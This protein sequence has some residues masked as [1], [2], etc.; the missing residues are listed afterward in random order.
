[1][2]LLGREISACA[3]ILLGLSHVSAH[4]ELVPFLEPGPGPEEL[5]RKE[6]DP[7]QLGLY[8]EH[9][10]KLPK[11]VLYSRTKVLKKKC[12]IK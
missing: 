7:A 9:T 8:K 4:S 2:Y 3:V 11:S 10:L 12:L 1:M 5:Q 6:T